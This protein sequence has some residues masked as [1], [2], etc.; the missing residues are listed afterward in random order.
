MRGVLERCEEIAQSKGTDLSTS[1]SAS[2]ESNPG[3]RHQ[4][5][6]Q[7]TKMRVEHCT[8]CR[9]SVNPTNTPSAGTKH[10]GHNPTGHPN[11]GNPAGRDHQG[12]PMR[13]VWV[14]GVPHLV[15]DWEVRPQQG[16]RGFSYY[17]RE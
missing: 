16:V 9:V 5:K 6:D 2:R 17:K 15:I 12:R 1:G 11:N 7:E 10:G 4:A 13:E 3:F 8:A 14:G